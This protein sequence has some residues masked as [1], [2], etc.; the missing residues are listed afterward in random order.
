MF[1]W[2][3]GGISSTSDIINV[4]EKLN[5]EDYKIVTNWILKNGV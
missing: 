2:A 3:S 1:I 5:K 4:C